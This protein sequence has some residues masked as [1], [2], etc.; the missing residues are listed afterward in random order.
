LFDAEKV[1]GFSPISTHFLPLRIFCEYITQLSGAKI[2]L[3][4]IE[5]SNTDFG[6]G[7]TTEVASAGK[8]ILENLLSIL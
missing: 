1:T 8:R 2:A 3:L 6:E 7:L 5:P 4:L